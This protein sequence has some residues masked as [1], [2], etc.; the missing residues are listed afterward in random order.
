LQKGVIMGIL[1]CLGN[2]VEEIEEKINSKE[3]VECVNLD[4]SGKDTK[5]YGL[6]DGKS[7]NRLGENLK[8][9]LS[10]LPYEDTVIDNEIVKKGYMELKTEIDNFKGKP[11]YDFLAELL[12]LMK[13]CIE[14]NCGLVAIG[15]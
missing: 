2:S 6:I 14:R 11:Y 4:Y 13:L 12:D 5:L 1:Y 3:K 15:D 8:L 7:N 10:V 9:I